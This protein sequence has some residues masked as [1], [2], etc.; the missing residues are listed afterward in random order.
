MIRADIKERGMNI[1]FVVILGL[2][3]LY[4]T[5]SLRKTVVIAKVSGKCFV[6]FFV[7]AAALSFAPV[8]VVSQDVRFNLSGLFLFLA[9]AVYLAVKKRYN[10][11]SYVVSL[12]T[13]LLAVA[14]TFFF[15]SYSIPYMTY[16]VSAFAAFA[17]MVCFRGA[18][19]TFAPVLVGVYSA[20]ESMMRML[21]G[22][23]DITTLF[24]GLEMVSLSIVISLVLAYLSERP[25]GRHAAGPG[26]DLTTPTPQHN[27]G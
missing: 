8:I 2:P 12:I 11:R 16:I 27:K 5:G 25:K 15:N 20:S 4:L 13:V 6:L 18:A 10:F 26:Q 1:S 23:F 24:D 3:V 9:P 17:A 7:I 19:F 22:L 14:S 21:S